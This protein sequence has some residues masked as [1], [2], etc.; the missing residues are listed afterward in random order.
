MIVRVLP[1]NQS[2][3]NKRVLQYRKSAKKRD[4]PFA[5]TAEQTVDLLRG[6]CDYCG[7]M[8]RATV[9]SYH[10]RFVCNGIDRVDNARGYEPGNVV[11]CCKDCNLAKRALGRA[12]FLALVRRI[13]AH[14]RARSLPAP[15][16]DAQPSLFVQ[17]G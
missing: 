10:S 6:D 15:A 9:R 16:N 8:P 17:T 3:I 1:N 7:A 2:A 14:Q 11:S 13:V 12:E 5:L 4:L